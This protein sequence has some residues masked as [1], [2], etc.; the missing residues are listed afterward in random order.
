MASAW[1]W[2]F[3]PDELGEQTSLTHQCNLVRFGRRAMRTTL[4]ARSLQCPRPAGGLPSALVWRSSS[5]AFFSSAVIRWSSA[6]S[7][8]LILSARSVLAFSN[9]V[10]HQ[11]RR[12]LNARFLV[13]GARA[14]GANHCVAQLAGF[15]GNTFPKARTYPDSGWWTMESSVVLWSGCDVFAA[16]VVVGHCRVFLMPVRA[17]FSRL[18]ASVAQRPPRKASC[19]LTMVFNV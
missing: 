3:A 11:G 1:A 4:A 5:S 9:G 16:L 12:L 13:D 8:S 18:A 6:L 14:V 19:I 10:G 17:S 15:P 7:A 2:A